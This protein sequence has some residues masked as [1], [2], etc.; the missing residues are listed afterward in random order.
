MYTGHCD[1]VSVPVT[2][3]NTF[4]TWY[5]VVKSSVASVHTCLDV[6]ASS[7]PEQFH[8]FRIF[9]ILELAASCTTCIL[10]GVPPRLARQP[11][12]LSRRGWRARLVPPVY[13]CVILPL[14]NHTN[15]NTI[16]V[17]LNSSG[18]QGIIQCNE[19]Q[20]RTSC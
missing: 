4:S 3:G 13:T 14:Q 1:S 11:L 8:D 20:S 12:S 7:L 15:S 9:T 18:H 19:V 2:W 5:R 6:V 16:H 17:Q 10:L